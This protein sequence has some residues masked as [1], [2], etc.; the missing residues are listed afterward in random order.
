MN[1]PHTRIFHAHILLPAAMLTGLALT[2]CAAVGPDYVRPDTAGAPSW[3]T[4]LEGG[5]TAEEISPQALAQWWTTFNDAQLSG[6]IERAV[7]G[8]LRQ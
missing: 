8:N 5:L 7:A 1:P 4:S 6:L 3:H 2:G